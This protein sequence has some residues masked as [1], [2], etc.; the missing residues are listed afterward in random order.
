MLKHAPAV[1]ALSD[2]YQI[3]VLANTEVL[4]TVEVSGKTF[5]DESGGVMRSL[6]PLHRVA[7]PMQLLNEARR[8][9]VRL[10]PVT[11]RKPYFTETEEEVSFD[12]DF[13]PV[14]EEGARA[15][16]LADVH[17]QTERAK[18]AYA[19][20]GT[21]DFLILNGDLIEYCNDEEA[22]YTTLGL[23][24]D[25]SEGR[26]P[27]VFARGNHDFR[28]K[29]AERFCDVFPTDSGRTYYTFRLGSVWGVVL[30]CGEDKGDHRPEYG[31]TIACHALRERQTRFLEDLVQNAKNGHLADGVKTRL[32]ICHL[33][34]PLTFEEPFDIE[35]ALYDAWRDL[36]ASEIRPHAMLSGHTHSRALLAKGEVA[37]FPVLILSEVTPDAL[38]GAGLVFDE[39]RVLV[40]FTDSQGAVTKETGI[41]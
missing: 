9:T 21:A 10:R 36:I 37:P 7:V 31:H 41:C 38:T 29:L 3:F 34:F 39:S 15:Y 26:I 30:D 19:A 8:Y 23:C 22:F 17:G 6:T 5:W 20:F 35:R 18:A 11:C 4:M 33:P 2:E 27:L 25:L 40:T 16:H 12:F 1:F 24:C 32:V 14:P 28:G 13:C